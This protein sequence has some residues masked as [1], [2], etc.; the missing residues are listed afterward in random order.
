M[1][2]GTRRCATCGELFGVDGPDGSRVL[3]G[4]V[5]CSEECDPETFVGRSW[6]EDDDARGIEYA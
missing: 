3:P 4:P 2:R 5:Y 1:T 6:D